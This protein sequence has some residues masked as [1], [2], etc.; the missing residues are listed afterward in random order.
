MEQVSDLQALCQWPRCN[1]ESDIICLGKGLCDK[2]WVEYCKL[3]LEQAHKKLGVE[4]GPKA[5]TDI[6]AG[7]IL[8][9]E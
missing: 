2:H 7:V 8:P 3:P 4:N 9:S 5:Q 1:K 6:P